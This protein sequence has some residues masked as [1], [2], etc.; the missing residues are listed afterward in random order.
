MIVAF[1]LME[2]RQLA[3]AGFPGFLSSLPFAVDI[4]QRYLA[5]AEDELA[6]RL[7]ADLSGAGVITR[8]G[9]ILI[10]R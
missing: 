4:N 1:A 2:R 5:L 6:A 7:L 8:Q 10:I 3:A 9:D